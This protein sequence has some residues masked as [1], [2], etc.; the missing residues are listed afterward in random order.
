M[1]PW[2]IAF[3]LCVPALGIGALGALS[4]RFA[5]RLAAAE[6][7]V[8]L[9]TLMLVLASFAWRQDGL[10]D[11]ALALGLLAIPGTLVITHFFERWL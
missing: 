3:M 2:L 8:C 5:Q 10:I 1:S 4:G 11:L 6:L 9:G 7:T